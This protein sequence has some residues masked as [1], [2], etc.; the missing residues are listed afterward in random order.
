MPDPLHLAKPT[1][2]Y[3]KLVAIPTET[4]WSQAYNAGSLFACLSLASAEPDETISLQTLGKDFLNSLEAE[5]FTLEEKNLTMIKTA[6]EKSLQMLPPTVTPS[7]CLGFIKENV[8]YLFLAGSGKIIMKRG[9]RIGVLLE[10]MTPT[11]SY[12]IQTASGY[13]QNDDS[14][15]LQTAQFAHNITDKDVADAF[16]L[17]LPN[18]IAEALSPK[19]HATVDG[20]QA[21]I[22]LIYHG[23]TKHET[24]ETSG[25]AEEPSLA[26]AITQTNEIMTATKETTAPPK[27]WHVTIPKLPAFPLP[28]LPGKLSGLHL[29]HRK[30]LFLSIAAVL[31]ILLVLSIVFTKMTQQHAQ[32]H[33][34]FQQT[35]TSA[36]TNYTAGKE[37]SS[38][39][40]DLARQDFQK[41]HTTITAAIDKFPKNSTE[42]NQ[43]QNLLNQVDNQLTTSGSTAN[44]LQ[45]KEISVPQTDIL[46]VEK[47]TSGLAYSQDTTMIYEVTDKA[48]TTIAKSNG[49]KKTIITNSGQWQDPKA[50]VPYDG[51]VYILDTKKA[52]LKYV[53]GSSGFSKTNYFKTPPDV[54]TAVSMAID[55]SVYI[56][57]QDGTV[58]KFTSGQ[59]DAFKISGLPAPLRNP[60]RIFTDAT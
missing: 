25:E 22:I 34:L 9:N 32:L 47:N 3:A 35:Y 2:A 14:I 58:L 1:L 8:L 26:D 12:K 56:L 40:P 54:S 50:V 6:I 33:A 20:G 13:L 57:F 53:A 11:K 15:L 48:V 16:E 27:R 28:H 39:R 44:F 5:F 55:S 51:N 18:D 10:N 52:V 42:H 38:I 21:A 45:L 19:M 24:V 36:Q 49:T 41:A 29:N 4:G 60:T 17:T 23:F 30:K 37:M 43:L 59:P 7:F 46:A 31:I